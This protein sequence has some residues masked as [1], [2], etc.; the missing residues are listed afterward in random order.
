MSACVGLCALVPLTVIQV[1]NINVCFHYRMIEDFML[2]AN[3]AVARRIYKSFPELAV[4]RRHEE[5]QEKQLTDLEQMC[6]TLHLQVDTSS[7]KA[8]QVESCAAY[9]LYGII[10][11][12]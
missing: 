5:P 12:D 10:E 11:Q 6:E 1:R 7:S 2:L 3:M 9:E 8:L 4:L